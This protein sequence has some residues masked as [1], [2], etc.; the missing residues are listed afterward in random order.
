MNS[1]MCEGMVKKGLCGSWLSQVK[2]VNGYSPSSPMEASWNSLCSFEELI[3]SKSEYSF[4]NLPYKVWSHILNN[5]WVM[6]M[7]MYMRQSY[8]LCNFQGSSFFSVNKGYFE[9]FKP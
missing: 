8:Y 3:P 9:T 1:Q 7:A 6:Y 4:L 5:F 2:C